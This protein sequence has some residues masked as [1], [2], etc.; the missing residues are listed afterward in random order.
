MS[1]WNHAICRVVSVVVCDMYVWAH[2]SEL[3]CQV[4]NFIDG[5]GNV[6]PGQDS[7]D[8]HIVSDCTAL[9]PNI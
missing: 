9:T 4:L 8:E 3:F 2:A 5:S 1:T 6:R 7:T